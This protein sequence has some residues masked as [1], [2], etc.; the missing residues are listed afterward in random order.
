MRIVE[1][2]VVEITRF[3]S[4]KSI[5]LQL[6]TLILYGFGARCDVDIFKR[7]ASAQSI[8]SEVF[9]STNSNEHNSSELH[10]THGNKPNKYYEYF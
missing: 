2:K 3:L 1:L 9:V 4:P 6:F 10:T 8:Y 7:T 5:N